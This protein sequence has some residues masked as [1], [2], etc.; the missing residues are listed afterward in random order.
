MKHWEQTLE[1]YVYKP[2]QHMH[3]SIYFFNIHMKHLQR[4]SE[5]SKLL[6]HMFATCVFQRNMAWAARRTEAVEAGATADGST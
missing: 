5:T 2:L 3:I 4:V 1:T 6:E